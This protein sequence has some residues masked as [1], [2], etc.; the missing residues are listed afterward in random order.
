MRRSAPT[1][2]ACCACCGLISTPPPLPLSPPLWSQPLPAGCLPPAAGAAGAALAG[3]PGASV[4][5]GLALPDAGGGRG[6]PWG[7][8]PRLPRA[9]AADA[10]ALSSFL[11]A[12][13]PLF[14]AHKISSFY[15]NFLT[16]R[17]KFRCRPVQALFLG[18]FSWVS[19]PTAAAGRWRPPPT[20]HHQQ[21]QE[22]RS[23]CFRMKCAPCVYA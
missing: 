20:A 1:R 12:V 7:G 18:A 4:L 11:S 2:S 3:G 22:E 5:P 17:S 10:G 9:A 19:P 15:P 21:L 13:F 14:F 8:G 16:C 23:V 6:R